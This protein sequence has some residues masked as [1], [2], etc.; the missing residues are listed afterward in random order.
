MRFD[1][2]VLV[3]ALL[4][5]VQ[6]GPAGP[7]DYGGGGEIRVG[8]ERRGTLRS[9]DTGVSVTDPNLRGD[10]W[11]AELSSDE[12]PRTFTVIMNRFVDDPA[13]EVNW[14]DSAIELSLNDRRLDIADEMVGRNF[15]ACLK[16][17]VTGRATYH[18]LTM[19]YGGQLPTPQDEE[20]NPTQV[21]HYRLRLYQGDVS[22]TT[23]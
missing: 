11:Y 5:S 2:S 10:L 8:D 6:C 15:D 17:Q 23:P 14:L 9:T 18:F 13:T 20:L 12:T 7:R 4:A 16:F 3:F 22:C 19:Q 21:Y 1:R